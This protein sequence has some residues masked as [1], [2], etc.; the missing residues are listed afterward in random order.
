MKTF[1]PDQ[2]R[3]F[4]IVG[5]A[6]SGKTQLSESMLFCA[7]AI[8]RA[9]TVEAGT[10]TS[11]HH[12]GEIE[13]RISI[14]AT[15]LH[16]DWMDRKF[17]LIDTPGSLDFISEGLGALRVGD[18]ALIVVD[19]VQGV[20]VGTER[21][22]EYATQ[23]DIP[24][25]LV[26]NGSDREQ[27][28]F[29]RVLDQLRE[30]F[31]SRVFPLALP[32]NPGPGFNRVLDVLRSEV[33]TYPPEGG[34]AYSEAAATGD[35]KERVSQLHRELIEYIAESDDNLME[36][37][38]QQ[39]TLAEDELRTGVHRAIQDEAFTP[40]FCTSATSHAGVPR[41]MDFIAKYGSSPADRETVTAHDDDDREIEIHLNDAAPTLYVFKTLNEPH[42][43]DLSFFRLYSGEVRVGDE[44]YNSDRRQ[45][46]RV[47]QIFLL[48][49]ATREAVERLGAGDIGAVV[50]LRDT[51]TGNTLCSPDRPV[52]LPRVAYPQANIHAALLS[53]RGD[54]DRVAAGLAALHEE[55]PTF[56]HRVDPELHPRRTARALPRN[57]PLEG[58]I[59]VS[60]Q[61]A[62]RRRGPIRRGLDADC[63]GPPRLRSRFPGITG[64]AKRGPRLRALR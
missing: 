42:V 63:T 6:S 18:F 30:R 54:E 4:A 22:W 61:E 16:C 15:P 23:Y 48:N 21:A 8:N 35:E 1:P 14:H 27:A 50:K 44:L 55:D 11:D 29:D 5:H 43:G 24:K 52:K 32:L 56:I 31:G 45:R 19:A 9:G 17:N 47:G 7:G 46:E 64:R 34:G 33:V 62:I 57:D 10:T 26:I 2:P 58:G 12:P 49:G 3:N 41:L 37:F 51:H 28:S 40:V 38:F 25:M 20:G 13:R 39:G 53:A 60:T 36:R 59:T